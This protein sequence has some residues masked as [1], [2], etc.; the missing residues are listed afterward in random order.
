M[1][2][3]RWS[4]NYVLSDLYVSVLFRSRPPGRR[5]GPADALR[6]LKAVY[7]TDEEVGPV[8]AEAKCRESGPEACG[9]LLPVRGEI[10]ACSRDRD[11][12]LKVLARNAMI[13]GHCQIE[14][15]Q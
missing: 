4:L 11:M 10:I 13:V 1:T 15:R 2:A 5:T 9:V 7:G 8:L 14:L 6:R 12:R 3:D